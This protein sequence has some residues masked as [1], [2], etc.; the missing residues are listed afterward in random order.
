MPEAPQF[1]SSALQPEFGNVQDAEPRVSGVGNPFS[2]PLEQH[3]WRSTLTMIQEIRKIAGVLYV[4]GRPVKDVSHMP[5]QL[6]T[7]SAHD[8][9]EADDGEES[10]DDE[11]LQPLDREVI[12]KTLASTSPLSGP[13]TAS[14]SSHRSFSPAQRKTRASESSRGKELGRESRGT[15]GERRRG[16][17]PT[18]KEHMGYCL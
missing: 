9:E 11:P 12:K 1:E 2:F 3:D 8:L 6:S 4:N 15:R 7:S 18:G 16:R 10:Y 13:V 14:S 17:N 5:R